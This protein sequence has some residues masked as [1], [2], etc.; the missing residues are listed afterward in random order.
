MKKPV[1][2][3]RIGRD[4]Q[5]LILK[6]Y[7]EVYNLRRQMWVSFIKGVFAGL[8]GVVG[9]TVMVA[10]LLFLLRYFGD[11]P[12]AGRFFRNISEII[13]SYSPAP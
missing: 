1:D 10:L 8:G 2:Y 7:G 3:E 5:D 12:G 13:R 6:G 11:L 4:A 9:A